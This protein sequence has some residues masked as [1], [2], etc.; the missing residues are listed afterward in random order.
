MRARLLGTL[1]LA[2]VVALIP[3]A[4]S[5]STISITGGA[6][7]VIPPGAG[8]NDA[9]P[10]LF[11]GPIIGGYFGAQIDI[12]VPV[13]TQV[14][15]DFFG[16]EAD[17]ANEFDFAGNTIFSHLSGTLLSSSI[18]SPLSTNTSFSILGSGLL[19][20]TF[21]VHSD[22]GH[23][24]N[25]S[26]P[27]SLVMPNFF[28]SCDPFGSA[29][30]SGGRDCDTIYLFLDDSGGGPDDDYDDM[31]VRVSITAVPEPATL[32]LLGLGLFGAGALA[33][34]RR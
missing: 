6:A 1:G 33:R 18:G 4:T 15:M 21:D 19:P 27:N 7:G 12:N 22:A 3:R 34:R 14:R 23:V 5:A 32:G 17:F 20:F 16:G 13:F 30:G 31:I 25:G 24:V 28:A 2:L 9:I 26:N 11:P 10:G 8:A 29:A